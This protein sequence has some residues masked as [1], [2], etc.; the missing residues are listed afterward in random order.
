MPV[1]SPYAVFRAEEWL[2]ISAMPI[3][4]ISLSVMP[5]AAMPIAAMPATKPAAGK[6][7]HARTLVQG[8][9]FQPLPLD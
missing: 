9:L 6:K 7:L 5:I 8:D 2:P 1:S 3:K 4:A